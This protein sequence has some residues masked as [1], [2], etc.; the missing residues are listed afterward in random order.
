MGL[1]QWLG[2]YFAS[3]NLEVFAV[4][5]SRFLGP[6]AR[7][8]V[9]EFLPHAAGITQVRA[10]RSELV[11]IA[12]AAQ[13]H[14][15]PP[16]AQD[17]ERG[18]AGRHVQ[19]MM[20]RRQNDA[21]AQANPAGS[22]TDR[23]KRQVRGA[24]MRP[25]RTKM[26]LGKPDAGKALLLGEGNLFQ[27]LIDALGFTG[28]GPGF[29]HLDLVEQ[30][31]FHGTASFGASISVRLIPDNKRCR[32]DRRTVNARSFG[33][34]QDAV[35]FDDPALVP[36][37]QEQWPTWLSPESTFPASRQPPRVGLRAAT[38]ESGAARLPLA[39][40]LLARHPIKLRPLARRFK[41]PWLGAGAEN[42]HARL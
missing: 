13:A 9:R 40:S 34:V 15:H 14:V 31:Q 35:L 6:D 8:H 16:V 28:W 1:L 38:G 17:I 23:G 2:K 12:G 5:R 11:R 7:Q 21:D 42:F 24:I 36:A 39:D 32:N 30:T 37:A 4:V 29:G 25:H 33:D 10:V 27:S 18:H 19:R 22:L 26:M 3:G 41:R 20:N